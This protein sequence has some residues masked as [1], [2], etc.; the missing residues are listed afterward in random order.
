MRGHLTPSVA[1]LEDWRVPSGRFAESQSPALGSYSPIKI[2][3]D[4]D[5]GRLPPPWPRRVSNRPVP[6]RFNGDSSVSLHKRGQ[7]I[8]WDAVL[9]CRVSEPMPA[10][11]IQPEDEAAGN[12]TAVGWSDSLAESGLR[13]TDGDR[14]NI[15]RASALVAVVSADDRFGS[16]DESV[17]GPLRRASRWRLSCSSIVSASRPAN[18]VGAGIPRPG[19]WTPAT[20][21][22]EQLLEPPSIFCEHR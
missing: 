8:S 20:R 12:R 17:L 1:F 4:G 14:S 11:S 13:M 5:G 2:L 21:R 9:I 22:E 19:T 10:P 16:C 7:S 18:R 6:S 15:A 3:T